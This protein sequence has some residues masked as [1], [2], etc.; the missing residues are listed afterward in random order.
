MKMDELN[1]RIDELEIRYAHQEQLL[2]EL[3]FGRSGKSHKWQ[4]TVGADSPGEYSPWGFDI[5]IVD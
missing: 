5:F 2:D 1:Q 3:V 4:I